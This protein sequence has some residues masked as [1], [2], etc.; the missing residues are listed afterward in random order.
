MYLYR[1]RLYDSRALRDDVPG[2]NYARDPSKDPEKNVDAELCSKAA[3]EC[4]RQGWDEEGEEVETDV[5]TGRD[6]G[7][8]D[9]GGPGSNNGGL[10]DGGSSV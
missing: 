6:V 4:D 7:P 8:S 5:I 3:F 1:R 9:R 2:V 10:D